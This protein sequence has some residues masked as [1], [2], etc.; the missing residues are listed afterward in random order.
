MSKFVRNNIA[1]PVRG[2]A[3]V[4]VVIERGRPD[5]NRIVIEKS[6]AIGVVVKVLE[7]DTHPVLGLVS[8]QLRY[9]TIGL[10]GDLRRPGSGSIQTLVIENPE[11]LGLHD[12][13]FELGMILRQGSRSPTDQEPAVQTTQ[14]HRLTAIL[15]RT[16][17]VRPSAAEPTKRQI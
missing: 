8:V 7:H 2:S 4:E 12:L 17:P 14:P 13:P 15:T 11:M 16:S 1:Q 3:Q 9:R 10:F 5:L 6:R